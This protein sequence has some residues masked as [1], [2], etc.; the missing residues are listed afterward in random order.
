LKLTQFEAP[1]KVVVRQSK[2]TS[3]AK[4]MGG[5]ASAGKGFGNALMVDRVCHAVF[6]S[7]SGDI[8]VEDSNFKELF[9]LVNAVENA[10]Q[11]GHL[12]S[13]E[14]FVLTDNAG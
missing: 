1:P 7:W 14:L 13:T 11:A 5:D 9:N 10:H 4:Y 8:E 12:K 2:R 3:S 6:G